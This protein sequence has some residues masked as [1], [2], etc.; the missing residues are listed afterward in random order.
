MS[1]TENELITFS[2]AKNKFIE[3][4]NK[5]IEKLNKE[6][7]DVFKAYSNSKRNS[8]N[9][10]ILLGLD[11]NNTTYKVNR[12]NKLFFVIKSLNKLDSITSITNTNDTKTGK[13]KIGKVIRYDYYDDKENVDIHLK[14]NNDE[15]EQVNQK[16]KKTSKKHWTEHKKIEYKSIIKMGNILINFNNENKNDKS[17]I[18]FY[19][20]LLSI[21]NN[22][23][24]AEKYTRLIFNKAPKHN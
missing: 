8:Y 24:Q 22:K 5:E 21:L 9:Q 2:E 18:N 3:E 19:E 7:K 16:N 14:M 12:F 20:L 11:F 10:N 15:V 13:K 23:R 17:H 1:N 4:I 6:L